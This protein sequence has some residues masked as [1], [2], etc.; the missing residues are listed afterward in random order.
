[1]SFQA[2]ENRSVAQLRSLTLEE[3]LRENQERMAEVI[4]KD[5]T[6]IFLLFLCS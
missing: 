2:L 3:R 4:G 6:C 1:M 5:K